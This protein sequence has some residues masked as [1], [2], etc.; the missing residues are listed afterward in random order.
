MDNQLR[1]RYLRLFIFLFAFS[2]LI[3]QSGIAEDTSNEASSDSTEAAEQDPQALDK[4]IQNL[5]REVSRLNRDLFI[6]EEELLFPASTQVVVFVSLNH[7]NLFKLDAI[8]LKINDETVASHLYTDREISSLKRG[9]VQRLY[10]G[11][12]QTGKHELVAFFTG[13]GPNQVEYRRGTTVSFEKEL[14]TKYIELKI[15]DDLE[16]QQPGFLVKEW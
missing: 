12:I 9:G 2:V 4:R 5:K 11:N 1:N 6:L 15:I 13:Q 10:I 3:P 8:E 16:K 7:G 14:S